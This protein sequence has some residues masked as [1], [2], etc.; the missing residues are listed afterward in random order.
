MLPKALQGSINLG[1][2]KEHASGRP[3]GRKTSGS[4]NYGAKGL[5][6]HKRMN[7]LHIL[8]NSRKR[9]MTRKEWPS[10]ESGGRK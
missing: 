8:V 1:D 9:C 6:G 3:N 7:G 4:G 2:M 10:K 5:G